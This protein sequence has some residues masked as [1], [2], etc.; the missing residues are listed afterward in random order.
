MITDPKIRDE[1][2]LRLVIL[3]ALRYEKSSSNA[4]R[5]LVEMLIQQG[6]SDRKVA[7]SI[8]TNNT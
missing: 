4:T 5:H 2:K 3:Y 1:N 7:V 6:L 8:I